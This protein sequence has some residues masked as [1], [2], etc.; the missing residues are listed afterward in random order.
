MRS[1]ALGFFSSFVARMRGRVFLPPARGPIHTPISSNVLTLALPPSSK[2]KQ[3][4][5]ARYIA[6]PNKRQFENI[7]FANNFIAGESS[8]GGVN[9]GGR[10]GGGRSRRL[11]IKVIDFGLSQKY[12][13][14]LDMSRATMSE[15]VGTVYTMA[16]EVLRGDYTL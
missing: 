8:A 13:G 9:D 16:P 12:G 4:R 5:S 15:F 3:I 11:E 2:K 10:G 6:R 7:M 1:F 14:G